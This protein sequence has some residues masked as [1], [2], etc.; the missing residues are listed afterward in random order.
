MPG[1]IRRPVPV[2]VAVDAVERGVLGR[3][4]AC[5]RRATSARRSRCA[6]SSSRW[7]SGGRGAT[8]ACARPRRWPTPGPA[9][10]AARIRCSASRRWCPSP[11]FPCGTHARGD[12]GGSMTTLLAATQASGG[13]APLDQ[14]AI[15]GGATTL[16]TVLT[17]WLVTAYRRGG[18]PA[19]R[20]PSAR[21]AGDR[22]SRLGRPA[23]R[24]RDRVR[25]GD[26]RRRDLGHRAAHRPRPR[27]GTARHDRALPAP[28]RPLRRLPHGRAR[29]G[30]DP[31]GSAA[32]ELGR[33][34]RPRA[35]APFPPRRRCCSRA[36]RSACRPSRSTTS[37]TGSSAR[38]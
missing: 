38:T 6:A 25:D 15:I 31:D 34:P 22:H 9:T 4:A 16:L 29:R 12:H 24:R 26:H 21:R 8:R 32:L 1:F 27:R 37:G 18:A 23:R 10:S 36:R 30:H 7:S 5:G 14:L 20:R 35:S 19:L 33:L 3:R 2:S 17:L 28:A 11:R 13:G